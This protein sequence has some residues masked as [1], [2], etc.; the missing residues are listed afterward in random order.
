MTCT[1]KTRAGRRSSPA[2]A[3]LLPLLA[4][5]FACGPVEEEQTSLTFDTAALSELGVESVLVQAFLPEDVVGE[6]VDCNLLLVDPSDTSGLVQAASSLLE[7][8]DLASP[9]MVLMMPE[10]PPGDTW[11][12]VIGFSEFSGGGRIVAAGCG[13][14]TIE[15]GSKSMVV[16]LMEPVE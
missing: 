16:V 3:V 11:F 1:M 8:I 13:R 7:D 15:R 10:L 6:D 9:S 12:L 14:A 4:A 5:L 2:A